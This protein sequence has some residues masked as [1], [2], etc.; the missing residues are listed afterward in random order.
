MHRVAI[1]SSY[2]GSS[3]CYEVDSYETSIARSCN[4]FCKLGDWPT[5]TH[6]LLEPAPRELV[7]RRCVSSF[8]LR[9]PTVIPQRRDLQ[10]SGTHL[11]V[12]WL[13]TIG[14]FQP[15]ASCMISGWRLPV[16]PYTSR[17]NFH[18]SVDA[19]VVSHGRSGWTNLASM[20]HSR[21]RLFR[22]RH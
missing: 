12:R 17:A 1:S 3:V 22:C 14:V 4:N 6:L 8:R 5:S 9:K 16:P 7:G 13:A 20:N 2:I 21:R 18:D 19:F 11:R 10:G 15:L